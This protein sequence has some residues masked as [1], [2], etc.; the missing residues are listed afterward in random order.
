V[1]ETTS[2]ELLVRLDAE[3]GMP[4]RRQ[5][6]EQVRSAIREGRL[7]AGARLP[8]TRALAADLG[9]S[10]GVVIDAYE[11][12][13]AEGYLVAHHGSATRVSNAV[14]RSARGPAIP[15]GAAERAP[16]YDF[17]PGAPDLSLFPRDAWLAAEREMLRSVP[18]SS[19]GYG[20]PRGAI[21]LRTALAEYLGRV[22]GAVADPERMVIVSGLAQ[23]LVLLARA[24]LARGIRRVAV[25]DPS[26][27]RGRGQLV[28][29][30]IELVPVP[31]DE[32]GI[33]VEALAATGTEAVLVT[34]AHQ[35][36]TGV[37][38]APER[39]AELLAWAERTGALI[40]EDDYDAEY[41]YDREPVGALQGLGHERVI[42]GGTVSM[43]L[44]PALRLGWLVLPERIDAAVVEQKLH[45]DLGSGALAQL[46]FAELLR[47]GDYD[48][49]LRRSRRV[50]RTR[51][52]TL[53][54]ALAAHRPQARPAGV[55]AGL[56]LTAYLPAD[57]DED[58]IRER[59]AQRSVAVVT[60]G[61]HRLTPGPPA[62]LLGYARLPEPA[63][64]RGIHELARAV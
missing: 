13:A 59:A 58:A 31:V 62:L 48:R 37:V 24:L 39:R 64:R 30:G 60:M 8:A 9:V 32:R 4:L 40:I 33:V 23:G 28:A 10:R 55:A 56:H 29:Q 50:Y 20:D 42:Y 46:T 63:L 43:T 49:H 53:L 7:V 5:L 16:R 45:D 54:A 38:L 14:G 35:F 12:L 26:H 51:R 61:E 41:R 6:T 19:L 25:E 57:A 27:A 18:D 34:P 3:A 22:R 21:E 52:D 36:P 47:R 11:Q 2:L 17:H 15:R 1:D 44:A